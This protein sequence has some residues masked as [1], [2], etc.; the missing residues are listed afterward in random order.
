[1]LNRNITIKILSV[2]FAFILWLYVM[3]EKNPEITTDVNNIPV[4]IVNIDSLDKKG[5]TL[6]DNKSYYVSVKVKGRRSDIMDLKTSDIVAQADMSNI[7][8]KGVN[9]VSVDISG[10]S[11]SISLVSVNPPEIKVAIDSIAKVQIPVNVKVSGNVADGFAMKPAIPSPGE[12]LING[13]ESKI[14]LVKN[15]IAQVDM[16]YKNKDVKISVPA[17]A[18]DRN[19]NEVKG[20][21]INP[22]FVTV[23]ISVNKAIRVPVNAR[24]FG[25]PKD[26]YDIS[27]LNVLPE[28]VY[29]T[30]DNATLN[31][32][33][34]I[35]SKQ[36]D[37]SGLDH[38]I[39]QNVPLD[40]PQGVSLVKSDS[41]VKIYIDIEKIVTKDIT[42]NNIE[43]KDSNN[44]NV[45]LTNT[46]V[47]VTVS[48]LE[49]VVNGATPDDFSAYIDISN[50]NSGKQTV[51][52][53]VTT[54]KNLKV[55]KINPTTV[56]INIP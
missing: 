22:Q 19:N 9:V 10:L 25:K 34:S 33:K 20:V 21:N 31:N 42:L 52:V 16:S 51:N 37:I 41:T 38:P 27:Q 35:S 28:Y 48:G 47:T 8:S 18:V 6:L 5:L 36:I 7:S 15:V 14:N 55:L 49:S 13:P 1:M 24:I 39:T 43:V 23:S 17:I 32:I 45:Q 46:P 40:L 44:R 53:D 11:K 30:G 50:L 54:T 26:G 56:N 3:G 4:R 29:I 12:V 2:I